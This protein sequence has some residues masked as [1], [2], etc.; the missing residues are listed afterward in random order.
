[1]QGNPMGTYGGGCKVP[2]DPM[3]M[4]GNAMGTYG[5][6]CSARRMQGDARGT[7]GSGCKVPGGHMGMCA[8]CQW[9][10]GNAKRTY[11]SGCKVPWEPK[12]MPGERMRLVAKCPLA[13]CIHPHTFAWHFA[14]TP[15][16]S[17]G[18][19]QHSPGTLHLPPYVPLAF[20][21][22]PQTEGIHHHT[23]P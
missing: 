7:Y 2:G 3:G 18:I 15:I 1:M 22:H 11:G 16:R 8:L 6:G 20:P 12:G 9:N 10:A 21:W 23:L 14:P 4:L 19:P 5:S 13:Q 17:P